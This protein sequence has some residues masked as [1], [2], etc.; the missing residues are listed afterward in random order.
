MEAA[1]SRRSSIQTALE[2]IRRT[3]TF[4]TSSPLRTSLM[5]PRSNS[6]ELLLFEVQDALDPNSRFVHVWH[7]LLLLCVG[8]EITILPYLVVFR[9]A[10]VSRGTAELVLLYVCELFFLAD[11]YVELNTGFYEGGDVTR[12]A[13]KS[14]TRYL[15]SPR[16]VL[17]VA[18][19]V[20]VSLFPAKRSVSVAFLE[21]HKLIRAWRIPKY[22]AQLDDVYAKYFVVLK[23]FK[24][25][26]GI[27]LLS[28]FLACVRFLF[29][30]D[31]HGGDHWLPHMPEQEQTP[32][33]KYLMS[34]FWSFGVMTGLFEGELPHTIAAFVFTIFVAICGF[35]LF[36]YL[37]ATFFMISKCESQNEA[38]EAQINQFKHLLSY[39]H[40]PE[41]LRH[42][43]VEYLKR[44]YTYAESNDREAMRL[45]CPS[46]RKDVQVALMKDTVAKVIIFEGCNDQ[47]IVAI[48]SLLEMISLPAYFVLFHAG[49]RGD[50]MYFVNSGVLHVIVDG[51]KV[52][53]ER[54]GDFF[55]EMSV[56][57]NRPRFAM[58]VT[59][60]Y[61]TLYKL[62]RFHLERVLDG[63]PEYAKQI[64]KQVEEMARRMF[65]GKS[66]DFPET[67]LAT[68][69]KRKTISRLLRKHVQN[70]KAKPSLGWVVANAV[71]KK[72]LIV[73]SQAPEL[74]D[75]TA[76]AKSENLSF[77]AVLQPSLQSNEPS[78]AASVA[79]LQNVLN[80]PPVK[81]KSRV[82][83]SIPSADQVQSSPVSSTVSI[84]T[85]VLTDSRSNNAKKSTAHE[86]PAEAVTTVSVPAPEEP[87]RKTS[88]RMPPV[89]QMVAAQLNWKIDPKAPAWSVLLLHKA[90]DFESTR[91]MWWILA[92]EIN[93]VYFWFVIPTRLAFEVLDHPNGVLS[94]LNVLME[95]M[96]WGDVYLNFNLSYIE[97]SEKILD[98][99]WTAR[100]YLRSKFS[101][102]LLCA[103]PH[104]AL[105]SDFLRLLRLLRMWR[106]IDHVKEVDEFLHL[107]NKRRLLLFGWLMI[108]LYHTV[109]CLHFSVSYLEGFSSSSHAWLPS[110]DLHLRRLNDTY[111]VD[112]DNVIYEV[113]S[114]EIIK[115]GLNQYF[116]SLYYACYVITALGRPVEPA[117]DTQFGAALVFM[118]SG[119][120]IT[121]IVV[122]NVQKRFTASAFEQKEFF[123]NRTRIQL[124]LMRQ[125]APLAI[126]KRVSAFLDFWWSAHRG[127][128]IGSLLGELPTTIKNDIM[129]SICKPALQTVA[130]LA[131]V[132]PVLNDLEQVFID[133]VKFI[134]YGQGEVVYRQGDFAGGLFFLL[135][136]ELCVIANGGAPRSIPQGSFIG[137][138]AL[139][140]EI[141]SP[142]YSERVMAISGCIVLFISREHLQLMRSTFPALPEALEALEKR[143]LDPKF[144]KASEMTTAT[145]VSSNRPFII[146]WLSELVF[147]PDS[148]VM[149]AWEAWIFIIMTA[150]CLLTVSTICFP[151]SSET[152]EIL[153]IIIFLIE[154]LFM[155]DMFVRFR[156]G[157]HEFG[158]KVMDLRVIKRNYLRSRSFVI[159]AFALLPL[160]FI[161][162]G[163][164]SLGHQH[165]EI[166]NLNKLVRLFKVPALFADLENK[167][168]KYTLQLRLF[169]LVYY[170][171][172][173][174]HTLGCFYFDFRSRVSHLHSKDD[175]GDLHPSHATHAHWLPE[176]YLLDEGYPL[177]Y[178]SSLFWSFGVMSATYPG[179]LPKTTSQ[180]VFNTITLTF[181]FFLFA[182]VIGNFSDIIELMDAENREYYATLSS[183]RHLLKHFSLPIAI[184]ERFK[185]Y[186]FFKR[187]HSITQEHLLESC[188]PPSLLTDIRMV[189]LQ[190]MIVK[191][192]FLAGMNGSVTRM[193][194]SH[195]SQ[196]MVVKDEFVYKYGEEGSDMYFVFAGLLDT[197]IP[198]ED[199][200]KH[201]G[202]I[203]NRRASLARRAPTENSLLT[204]KPSIKPLLSSRKVHPRPQSEW[205]SDTLD[206]NDLTKLNQVT[207]GDFFGENALFVDSVRNAFVLAKST[208]ILYKLSRNS[209]ETVFNRYPEW[210]QKV[211]RVINLQQQQQRLTHIA[212]MERHNSVGST[213]TEEDHMNAYA[214]RMEEA[215]ISARYKRSSAASAISKQETFSRRAGPTP[216]LPKSAEQKALKLP[217]GIPSFVSVFFRGAPAQSIYHLRWVKV[218]IFSTLF[219]S[220]VV[221]YR[222]S[223]DSM[224]HT[225]W[226]PIAIREL[227]ILCE[228][229]YVAD[230]WINWRVQRSS[231]SV[232]L[233]EQD[234]RESYKSDRLLCDILAAIPFD[235]L[236]SS[237]SNHPL[238]R[239]N[240]CLKLRNFLHYMDEI[241]RGSI[242]KEMHRL[243]TASIL[244]VVIMYWGACMYFAIAVYD[245]FGSEWNAW[246][247]DSSLADP[248]GKRTLRL[249]RG[250]FFATTSFIKKGRTFQPDTIFHFVFCIIVCFIGLLT[251]AFMVG[252]F[253]NLFISYINNEV[254]YRKNHIAVEMYL[255]RWKITGE[256]KARTQAFLSSLWS[257]HRGVDYQSFL[258][259]VPACIRTDSILVIAQAPLQSFV[260]DIFRPLPR[261]EELSLVNKLMQDIAQHLKFEGYPRGENVLVE[262]SITKSMYF[263]VRGY[264]F[265]TSE[266]QPGRG[267]SYG[268]GTYFGDKGILV[269]SVSTCSIHS[270]RACDLLS[271]GPDSLMRVL[272]N[273]R[274]M[275]LAYEIAVQAVQIVKARDRVV[276]GITAT[277]T[278]W[279]EAVLE[280]I[281]M[282]HVE[283]S[284]SGSSTD[285][286]PLGDTLED[287]FNP[288][289]RSRNNAFELLGYYVGLERAIDAFGAFR[290]LL[291]LLVPNGQLHNLGGAK[292]EKPTS[293]KRPTMCESEVVTTTSDDQQVHALAI[294]RRL[295]HKKYNTV[296]LTAGSISSKI[297][298]KSMGSLRSKREASVPS[299]V[300]ESLVQ[301]ELARLIPS[302]TLKSIENKSARE[303]SRSMGSFLQ[304]ARPL[305]GL[306]P[307]DKTEPTQIPLPEEEAQLI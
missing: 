241:N 10:A 255:G 145:V 203:P 45:L 207:A 126:H 272:Q 124:F 159:D 109:A 87:V 63:Y 258:E 253:A 118:L 147:D 224:E 82:A 80:T 59:T 238:Y 200:P 254:E 51:V 18:A 175:D 86:Q 231:E 35:L 85:Q 178:F 15:R 111:Y 296:A 42:Q 54:K 206:I 28:H 89:M 146:I 164:V 113:G 208:S 140:F 149:I 29:G 110:S 14:R 242:Y 7:Q 13:K 196:V 185:A 266:S 283:M 307:I 68:A 172:I 48:T 57:L 27:L 195:F 100:R 108:M 287:E 66:R 261:A 257:S 276:S 298:S 168:L 294:I 306:P 93:L 235:Y 223:F 292:V 166:L 244:Y 55:G 73:P 271:L 188:L 202:S 74:N 229:L 162:W 269:C 243:R 151:V 209:L 62:A 217:C 112:G 60:T 211:F 67:K 101:F 115:I 154:V 11:I 88:L 24:V 155:I 152:N 137:T 156:L 187:F 12:D 165:M 91:R 107:D 70:E 273:H 267:S 72:E 161:D 289:I 220:I 148:A 290:P 136:G 245:H 268:K 234:H 46:I 256:L 21:M 9:D 230:I 182:Y 174:S 274:I 96:L 193:L 56:F 121:A 39:H 181:G 246:L 291:Q 99:T 285:D 30:Y 186:F 183:F 38:S 47:F 237:V 23:M 26:V 6:V 32:R 104:W 139:H 214:E 221:P 1:A 40:V 81:D 20:P 279:G 198:R 250:C 232:D 205:T 180:C 34:I 77:A 50:A 249:L 117:S 128:V 297:S 44:Y 201:R 97:N 305:P 130:L 127:A 122:D 189:H 171:F 69:G 284:D 278:E 225:E 218:T 252:E 293:E 288:T 157:F 303:S 33:T 227:E 138:A 169:K 263:V 65:A 281:R 2:R 143:F 106:V 173:L 52:R 160:Y 17:D 37:C 304:V 43:A 280:S 191:V 184:Q 190:P 167:H 95:I 4:S 260:N 64:P 210:K 299:E 262:G 233:Y 90:I 282:K 61:C 19:L 129:K 5:R 142:S 41:E 228:V 125:N 163:L 79:P 16:F 212:K 105:G 31:E 144:L 247:P 49:D 71:A 36:T 236:V 197:L 153:D 116:R 219:M 240:R 83:S 134:L 150:Q 264:L 204:K 295:L 75:D 277:E 251:M 275:K 259:D 22:I 76:L 133:N 265:S 194:V 120:F 53:E 132:R 302:P 158:N 84:A 135:E 58:V 248:D 199:E 103:L 94:V 123:A 176:A 226:L 78:D 8:Y 177:Q 114:P 3:T 301:H 25:L 131:G 300:A 102:D 119:F 270:L 179:E 98:T 239:I 213:M 286:V 215:V 92:L 216:T 192:S 222:I 170:T 141:S